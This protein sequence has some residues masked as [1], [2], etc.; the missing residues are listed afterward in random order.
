M[1]CAAACRHGGG[2]PSQE[3][4]ALQQATKEVLQLEAML[5]EQQ[6]RQ[7]Q[8]QAWEQE[9][10]HTASLHEIKAQLQQELQNQQ[11]SQ[12]EHVVRRAIH[13]LIAAAPAEASGQQPAAAEHV[14]SV[15]RPA[16]LQMPALQPERSRAERSPAAGHSEL[17]DSPAA[18]L[19][20]SKYMQRS[21]SSG[22]VAEE[23]SARSKFS[24]AGR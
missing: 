14:A 24:N 1:A 18:K 12:I 3:A 17:L 11:A 4:A 6:A 21:A 5:Q 13:E 22:S 20:V 16:P 7:L 9:Q 19:L 2:Q 15:A 23:L 8:Q 10:Q